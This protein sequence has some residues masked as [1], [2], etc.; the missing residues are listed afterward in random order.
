MKILFN[1]TQWTQDQDPQSV[2]R[3]KLSLNLLARVT[4]T[5]FHALKTLSL[6]DFQALKRDT[7]FAARAL[8]NPQAVF[9]A[10]PEIQI[11]QKNDALEEAWSRFTSVQEMAKILSSYLYQF[12]ETAILGEALLKQ[13]VAIFAK[14]ETGSCDE[15]EAGSEALAWHQDELTTQ[16]KALKEQ[17]KRSTQVISPALTRAILYSLTHPTSP[18][19]LSP[20]L[21]SNRVLWLSIIGARAYLAARPGPIGMEEAATRGIGALVGMG[22]KIISQGLY[23][24]CRQMLGSKAV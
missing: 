13:A 3:F 4:W 7:V 6:P 14:I 2:Q 12:P 21:Q 24:T 8:Y 17:E 23:E 19:F 16:L 10:L 1:P 11:K 5:A 9:N 18:L 20:A 15:I 22:A